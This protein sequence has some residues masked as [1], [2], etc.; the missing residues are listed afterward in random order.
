MQIDHGWKSRLLPS[1]VCEEINHFR[2]A[3]HSQALTNMCGF[4][5]PGS[6]L[7]QTEA[8]IE[9]VVP[10]AMHFLTTPGDPKAVSTSRDRKELDSECTSGPIYILGVPWRLRLERSDEKMTAV[11]ACEADD[12]C[13]GGWNY[14][15]TAGI[16]LH[17]AAP[18]VVDIMHRESR[19]TFH[20]EQCQLLPVLLMD[21]LA[22]I[23]EFLSPDGSL[24]ITAEVDVSR[25]SYPIQCVIY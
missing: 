18:H 15:V 23:G 21:N 24:R 4:T 9:L 1:E 14:S 8:P 19:I 3:F 25:G 6:D 10:D 11:L 20:S 12:V 7:H 5:D 17:A 13:D 2:S 16:T 22:G